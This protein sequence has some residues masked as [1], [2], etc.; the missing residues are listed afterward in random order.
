LPH[1]FG[2]VAKVEVND[3]EAGWIGHPPWQCDVTS[4]MQQGSNRVEVTIIGTLKNTLGPH[5]GNPSLGTAWPSM[6][7]KGT[8]P[9]PPPGQEYHTVG[10][11]LFAPFE[12]EQ[13]F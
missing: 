11:G 5:H 9:G 2:S 1:W 10:Y 4:W 6:F 13:V 8:S 7:Q 12:V 3:Q